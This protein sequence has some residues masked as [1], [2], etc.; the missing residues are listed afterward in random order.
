MPWWRQPHAALL[1]A[2]HSTPQGLTQRQA[3]ARLRRQGLNR[4]HPPASASIAR[5]FAAR[6]LDPLILVLITASLISALT[7]DAVSFGFVAVIVVFSIAL[8][9]LQEHRAGRAVEA[10]QHTVALR[11]QAWRDGACIELPAERL[12]PGDCVELSAGKLVPADGRVLAATDLFVNQAAL[13]GEAYPVEKHALDVPGDVPELL[14]ATHAVF[15]GSTVVSGSARVLV[16]ATGGDTELGQLADTLAQDPPPTAF[17]RGTRRFGLLLTRATMALVLFVLLINTLHQRPLLESFLFAV[18]LA[19][20]LT[21]ELLPMIVSVTLARGAVRM[22]KRQVIVKRLSAVQD[23]GA[24]DVLCTDKTGT[25]TEA[26]LSVERVLDEQ[27]VPSRHV[28]ELAWLNSH[29]ETGLKAALDDAIL[30]H[31]QVDASAWR[32]LD[33][34]P[35][36]FER[37]RVSVLLE[38]SGTRLLIVKGAPEEILRLSVEVEVASGTRPLDA[39]GR[40]RI[41]RVFDECSA[42]GLRLLAVASRRIGDGTIDVSAADEHDFVFAG[43]VA[44]AD[45]PRASAAEALRSLQAHGVALKIITGDNDAVTRHLCGVL[46]LAVVGVL[47]G[48]QIAAMDD[49]AL[50]AAVARANLFCRVTPEQKNRIVRALQALGHVVG[51][52]GDGI[53]DAPPLH[54][55]DVGI[56]V[57]AAVDVAKQAADLVLLQHEL[58][59]L[60]DGV[61]EGRR[62]L[63]NVNKYILMATSSNFGNMTSMAAASLFL[64]FLPMRPV[65]I[66][67]NN[68]LYDVSEL[69]IPTD[70][71]DDADLQ[72]PQHW[73]IDFIRNFMLCF[74]PLSSV[75]DLLA[76]AV[77]YA[78]MHTPA[79]VFQTAWFVESMATQVFVIFVIRSRRASWRDRPSNWL[80][81]GSLAIVG[82]AVALPFTA[83]GRAFGFVALPAQ[84]LE[85]VLALTLAYLAA[86]EVMK[87]FFYHLIGVKPQ[88]AALPT[89]G[90]QSAQSAQSAQSVGAAQAPAARQQVQGGRRASGH[91]S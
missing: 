57:D 59:V 19:V 37:R 80:A 52:L 66:L 56:S 16:C 30:A 11:V 69:A 40:E 79:A 49:P 39:A 2:L 38:R 74:G 7:G 26:R 35:F 73:D 46:G 60:V 54:S 91:E 55:A 84:V 10:L 90:P 53:N 15:M 78:V 13:T 82:V 33:E 61:R 5:R 50:C 36:D 63:L 68:F 83:W 47:T 23:L 81:I 77:L 85:L 34:V 48:A 70:R 45:P 58:G 28:F 1:S 65:Q 42:Q 76:F 18:A 67:L 17:E 41:T 89:M 12:V 29:F 27:G 24:M 9:L 20:G 44:F 4:L 62:T 51:Y 14:A 71:V 32:K 21:P 3:A 43:F 87:L 75:F 64:P 88:P 25:L 72:V 31:G 22:A 6:L 86:A 8:D